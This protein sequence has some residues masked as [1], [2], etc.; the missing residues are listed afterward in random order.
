[1]WL[2]PFHQVSNHVILFLYSKNQ[3]WGG[4][5]AFLKE[6]ERVL[7]DMESSDTEIGA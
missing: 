1:M 4:V 5:S 3:G 2:G 7:E 6:N